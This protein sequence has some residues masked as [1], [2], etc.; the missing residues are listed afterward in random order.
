MEINFQL[1]RSN[2]KI[3][4]L[5]PYSSNSDTKMVLQSIVRQPSCDIS[6]SEPREGNYGLSKSESESVVT[7]ALHCTLAVPMYRPNVPSQHNHI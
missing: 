3:G 2:Q 6:I 5:V 1:D 7:G 4:F